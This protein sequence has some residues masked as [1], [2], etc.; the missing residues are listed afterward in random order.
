MS[1]S[2]LENTASQLTCH[3]LH[4]VHEIVVNASINVDNA[5]SQKPD[6]ED[7]PSVAREF[8]NKRQRN[9]ALCNADI[10]TIVALREF[11]MFGVGG[12][13]LETLL[14]VDTT[15]SICLPTP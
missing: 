5:D 3:L 12:R 14:I 13:I 11:L 9:M 8:A 2:F 10:T 4:L 6:A 1:C 15:V 7:S